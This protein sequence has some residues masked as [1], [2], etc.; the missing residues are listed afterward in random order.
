M[1]QTLVYSVT[2]TPS[3]QPKLLLKTG[4]HSKLF[5][6]QNQ[7]TFSRENNIPRTDI[8]HGHEARACSSHSFPRVA[9]LFPRKVLLWGQSLSQVWIRE[10]WS[11]KMTSI[12]NVASCPAIEKW[13]LLRVHQL[14]YCPCNIRQMV[15]REGISPRRVLLYMDCV[16]KCSLKGYCHS[17][18]LVINSLDFWHFGNKE[19]MAFAF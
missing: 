5:P 16:G 19:V 13:S 14:W 1:V 10:S 12:F 7:F 17:A 9:F 18:G 4:K 3:F 6:G 8:L 2:V 15:K 11:R